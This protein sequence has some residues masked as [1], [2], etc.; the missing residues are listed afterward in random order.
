M[1]FET[2]IQQCLHLINQEIGGTTYTLGQFCTRSD[3]PSEWRVWFDA[4]VTP[5][6]AVAGYMIRNTEPPYEV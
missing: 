1:T 6:A 4:G 5:H 3:H 2:W